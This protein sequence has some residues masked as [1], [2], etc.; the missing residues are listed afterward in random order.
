[1]IHEL[2]GRHL[3]LGKL[4]I[5]WDARTVSEA[6][7]LIDPARIIC[8]MVDIDRPNGGREL[9]AF[10]WEAGGYQIRCSRKRTSR[11]TRAICIGWRDARVPCPKVWRRA[12]W[13]VSQGR[14]HNMVGTRSSTDAQAST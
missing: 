11:S 12:G 1:M 14:P 5:T 3:I 4:I 13:R 6:H 7:P 8:D 10:H 9:D 2:N